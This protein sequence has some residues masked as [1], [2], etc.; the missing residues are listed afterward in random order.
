MPVVIGWPPPSMVKPNVLTGRSE[1]SEYGM[2]PAVT[3]PRICQ[4]RVSRGVDSA[5]RRRDGS[6]VAP[7]YN[8]RSKAPPGAPS[9]CPSP[10]TDFKSK[11]SRG[12]L[13]S[14]FHP[15]LLGFYARSF[16]RRAGKAHIG[17]DRIIS[18][19]WHDM[20]RDGSHDSNATDVAYQMM[21]ISDF[22][23][24]DDCAFAALRRLDFS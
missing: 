5:V 9:A 13:F 18:L 3:L 1:I 22:A 10:Y 11:H 16:K 20:Y 24:C 14:D 19:E 12:K 23:H 21:N 8:S 6:R 7:R 4:S 17:E 15:G 2:L